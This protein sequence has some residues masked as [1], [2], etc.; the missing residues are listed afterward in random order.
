MK[1]YSKSKIQRYKGI[2]LLGILLLLTDIAFAKGWTDGGVPENKTDTALLLLAG[3]KIL[4]D[5][6]SARMDSFMLS[7]RF[8]HRLGVEIRTDYI[9]PTNSFLRGDNETGEPI[10]SSLSAHL[11]YSFQF[12]PNTNTGRIYREAYQGVGLACYTFGERKQLGNPI[13]FYLFQGAR[14]NRFNPRLSLN[15]EWNFGLSFGWRPYDYEDNYYNIMIGS[16]I[17]AYINMDLYLNWMLS[18]QFDLTG[19]VTLSHFSDGNT[20]FPNAGL[21]TAGLNLGVVY[22][23]DRESQFGLNPLDQPFIPEFTRH[24]SYDLVL[25]GSWRRKGVVFGDEQVASPHAYTVLGFNF[26]PMYNFGYKFRAGISADGTYD[27]SANVYTEDYIVG[28]DQEFFKPSV[29]KQLALGISGRAEYVMPYF[30]IGIGMGVN[31]LHKGGDLKSFYQVLALK[32][33]VTR[34]SF[35]HIGYNL[36]DFHDPNFL[37]LGFGFRF[38]NKYPRFHR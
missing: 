31:V 33:E 6:L 7:R 1:G 17:N 15:Y 12:H 2:T 11:K 20:R 23:F 10:R 14:I 38:N 3:K 36:K 30:T 24:I 5:D 32:I 18:A 25:F 29:S 22:R 9:I 34:N 19:G 4:P 13:A 26:A 21:N 27:G 37:M 28:T 8:F 35:L 16:R